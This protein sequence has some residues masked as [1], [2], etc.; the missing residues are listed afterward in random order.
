[1]MHQVV[2]AQAGA[3]PKKNFQQMF[4][5]YTKEEDLKSQQAQL[6][7]RIFDLESELKLKDKA[8]NDA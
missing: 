4:S 2:P 8:L 3:E 1:M 6:Q 7:Q 5:Q